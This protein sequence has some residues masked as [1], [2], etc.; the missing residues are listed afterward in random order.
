MFSLNRSDEF[1]FVQ[2]IFYFALMAEFLVVR[3][4]E[5]R[6]KRVFENNFHHHREIEARSFMFKRQIKPTSPWIGSVNPENH[7]DC[8]TSQ[9]IKHIPVISTKY[10][11]S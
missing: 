8:Q 6:L 1:S 5:E 2:M 11:Y 9:G 4:T 7:N 10:F 3:C